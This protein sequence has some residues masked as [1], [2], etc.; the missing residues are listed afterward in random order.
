MRLLFNVGG[1]LAWPSSARARA[2]ALFKSSAC[3]TLGLKSKSQKQRL[4]P[5]NRKT[6]DRVSSSQPE[7][8]QLAAPSRRPAGTWW[9]V[10]Q[11]TD[12]IHLLGRGRRGEREQQNYEQ[13]SHSIDAAQLSYAITLGSGVCQLTRQHRPLDAGWSLA[14]RQCLPGLT[15]SCDSLTRSGE[16]AGAPPST[17]KAART[18]FSTKSSNVTLRC[19]RAHRPGKADI[20][21]VINPAGCRP[22]AAACNRVV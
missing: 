18:R 14:L 1:V 12:A 15:R 22:F 9:A 21:C 19:P 20:S 16:S 13:C 7:P 6:A 5:A 17:S 4:L 10:A 2:T 11:Q 3:V 8:M